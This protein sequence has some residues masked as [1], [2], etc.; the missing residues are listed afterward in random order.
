MADAVGARRGLF[1][2]VLLEPVRRD[3][4]AVARSRSA[5][6]HDVLAVAGDVAAVPQVPNVGAARAALELVAA[7]VDEA[8]DVLPSVLRRKDEAVGRANAA[9]PREA[10]AGADGPDVGPRTRG[11]VQVRAPNVRLPLAARAGRRKALRRPADPR[12]GSLGAEARP[13]PAASQE[14]RASRL[15]DLSIVAA[16]RPRF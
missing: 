7:A 12:T 8:D 1:P 13:R 15:V 14:V 2:V 4:A 16:F 11:A 6:G 9:P 3:A 10:A 5:A